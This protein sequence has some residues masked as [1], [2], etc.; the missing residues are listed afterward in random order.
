MAMTRNLLSKT[1]VLV[2][3]VCFAMLAGCASGG[4]TQ[5]QQETTAQSIESRS[6]E[7]TTQ[8]SGTDDSSENTADGEK[9]SLPDEITQESVTGSHESASGSAESPSEVSSG[10]EYEPVRLTLSKISE[11]NRTEYPLDYMAGQEQYSSLEVNFRESYSLGG[12]SLNQIAGYYPRV[13]KLQDGTY[14]LIFHGYLY[15]GSVYCM[16]SED[17]ETWTKPSYVFQQ[18]RVEVENGSPSTDVKAY[19]TP[20]F[21]QLSDGRILCVTAYRAVENY[22]RANAYNGLAIKFSED[23]GKTWGEE[24]DVYV[25]TSWEP[26]VMEADNGEIYIFWTCVGPSVYLY[27]IGKENWDYHSSGIGLIRSPDGGKSWIPDVKGKPFLPQYAMREYT[28]TENGIAIYNDQ[29]A[30]PLQLNNGTIALGAECYDGAHYTFSICY[31]DDHFAEDVGMDS[32]GPQDRQ[33]RIFSAAGPYLA[34]FDSGEVV[35]TYHWGGP[36][37]T[38]HYRMAD[39]TAH[40]FYEEHKLMEEVGMWGGINKVSSHS[41]IA[42]IGTPKNTIRIATAYLNHAI[43]AGKMEPQPGPD[44]SGWSENTDALFAGSDSQ[45]QVS[46]RAAWDE[47]NVYL[48][49]ERLDDSIMDGDT[50]ELCLDDGADGFYKIELD[51]NGIAGLSRREH[52]AASEAKEMEPHQAG[53]AA[54]VYIDGTVND[55]GDTDHGILYKLAVPRV[56]SG[57]ADSLKLFFTLGNVDEEGAQPITDGMEDSVSAKNKESWPAI[58]LEDQE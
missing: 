45:A 20:D 38:L 56:L 23:N 10:Q 28:R 41:V 48:L 12:K 42:A 1:P 15:G 51:N 52:A 34:Q 21:C 39:S 5:D 6:V 4:G 18:T 58:W 36:A 44:T 27:Q 55:S 32:T 7:V 9:E 8:E 57:N 25:G 31:S 2:A 53:V 30:A 43:H 29:M 13:R 11:L 19:M 16:A 3:A 33:D 37:A 26:V 35:L 22:Y 17:G 50:M 54:E 49:A 14:L 24:Q 47:E 46:L 40:T